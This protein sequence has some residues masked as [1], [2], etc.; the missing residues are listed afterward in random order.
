MFRRFV[1]VGTFLVAIICFLTACGQT[2][3]L[4]D[5][6]A[7]AKL[8]SYLDGGNADLVAYLQDQ[9]YQLSSSVDMCYVFRNGDKTIVVEETGAPAYD[10]YVG[11]GDGTNRQ[12]GFPQSDRIL[13]EDGQVEYLTYRVTIDSRTT[14]LPVA[15]LAEVVRWV[16]R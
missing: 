15:V 13:H 16:E 5:E 3:E 1:I 9:G 7:M 12:F 6:D 14:N 4:S 8:E 10:I 11:N 2:R